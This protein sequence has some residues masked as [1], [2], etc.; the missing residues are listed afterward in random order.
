MA[1]VYPYNLE[2]I[3]ELSKKLGLRVKAVMATRP[4]ILEVLDMV[5]KARKTPDSANPA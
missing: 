5:F 4:E 3:H 1:M 2:A